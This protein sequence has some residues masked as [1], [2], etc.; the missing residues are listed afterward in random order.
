MQIIAPDPA[1]RK[2]E[3]EFDVAEALRLIEVAAR[4][5]KSEPTPA[6]R[7]KLFQDLATTLQR[8]VKL[9][10]RA[11]YEEY[12]PRR[13]PWD[14]RIDDLKCFLEE[15]KRAADYVSD[16]FTATM[17]EHHPTDL[18]GLRGAR[19]V[20]VTEVEEGRRWAEGKIKTMTG[21]DKIS[22]RFMRQD[23]FEYIPQFKLWVAGNHKPR[24]RNVD[25]AM[26]R[27]LHLVPFAVTIPP[28]ER[29]LELADKLK[30]EWPGILQWLI[31]GCLAWQQHGL[32]PPPAV[33]DA[34]EEY[35]TA[36]DAIGLWI[37][38]RIERKHGAFVL[39]NALYTSWKDWI[40]ARGEEPGSQ[41]HLT[42]A[43]QS[44]HFK[45]IRRKNGRGFEGIAFGVPRDQQTTDG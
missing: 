22:A 17:Q 32:K 6:K 28:E 23:F 39:C 45:F 43:L 31:Q 20:T 19:L 11:R 42:E 7:R 27:R 24:L 13:T 29:D 10:T 14:S 8:A 36:E 35:F 9:A 2:A 15:T 12:T 1:T 25:E 21:G 26:R 5:D 38:D 18:A 34:T 33:R 37:E 30:A 4:I 16:T 40:Q 3:C 44:K 41:K